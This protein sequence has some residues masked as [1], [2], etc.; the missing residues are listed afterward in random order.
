MARNSKASTKQRAF[1]RSQSGVFNIEWIPWQNIESVE[2]VKTGA[3]GVFYL[4]FG[5]AGTAIVIKACMNPVNMLFSN[6]T[7][8]Q[9]NLFR[10]PQT[11]VI[12]NGMPEFK[13]M[14]FALNKVSQSDEILKH[15]IRQNMNR[16]FVVIMEYIPG[17]DVTHVGKDRARVLLHPDVLQV[18]PEE[19]HVRGW[20]AELEKAAAERRQGKADPNAP[21]QV[22]RPTTVLES[23]L[24]QIGK[25]AA[26][27]VFLNNP[28]RIPCGDIWINQGNQSNLFFEVEIGKGSRFTG[29][30]ITDHAYM[31]FVLANVTAIDN[32]TICLKPN[33]GIGAGTKNDAFQYYLASVER[34]VE[35][36][37]Q[38][39]K[40]LKNLIQNPDDDK[41]QF[42]APMEVDHARKN[43]AELRYMTFPSLEKMTTWWRF[44]VQNHNLFEQGM[45][46][47]LDL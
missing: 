15:Q 32:Q 40:R 17:F 19:S 4:S 5:K 34:F 3:T 9:L 39:V 46:P 42:Q 47:S 25:I 38:D 7:L 1:E 24:I 21:R 43:E 28:D 11:K 44:A 26:C 45:P 10:V 37:A 16:P 18:R 20:D 29:K 14:Q 30:E 23:P 8:E 22:G 36:L 41:Q 12:N 13:A 35:S 31:D 2:V 33:S 6:S 27:D